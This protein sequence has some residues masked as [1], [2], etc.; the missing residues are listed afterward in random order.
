M[1]TY[2]ITRVIAKRQSLKGN[3]RIQEVEPLEITLN[4][5]HVT[6]SKDLG[7]PEDFNE[8]KEMLLHD[9]SFKMKLSS[10]KRFAYI[11][12]KYAKDPF[13]QVTM[14]TTEDKQLRAL[15][16]TRIQ[17]NLRLDD[18]NIQ[19]EEVKWLFENT[20]RIKATLPDKHYYV[21]TFENNFPDQPYA[22][23]ETQ[24]TFGFKLFLKADADFEKMP[25]GLLNVGQNDPMNLN[26]PALNKENR[27]FNSTAY[28]WKLVSNYPELFYF[29]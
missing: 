14:I 17:D 22:T 2:K 24:W 16:K 20:S 28:I 7:L 29:A 25:V 10:P 4:D 12:D 21:N 15:V 13:F 5:G 6:Y 9:I 11:N 8:L 27:T 19:D 23:R 18:Y 3:L 26:N 1:N